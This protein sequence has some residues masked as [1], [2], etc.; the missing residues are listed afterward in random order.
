MCRDSGRAWRKQGLFSSALIKGMWRLNLGQA[1]RDHHKLL[2]SAKLTAPA[3]DGSSSSH[4]GV[5][6]QEGGRSPWVPPGEMG[7][8]SMPCLRPF[9][10]KDGMFGV[11]LES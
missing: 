4:L 8:L 2:F 7:G 1:K 9:L 5:L 10:G 11:A 6:H 3:E